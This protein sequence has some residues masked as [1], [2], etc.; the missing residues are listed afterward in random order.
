[1]TQAEACRTA[2]QPQFS[3]GE[4]FEQM[5]RTLTEIQQDLI[6]CWSHLESEF[7]SLDPY[8][9]DSA[10][11][12]VH[13]VALRRHDVRRLQHDLSR[14][15]ISSLGRSESY[16]MTNISKVLKLLHRIVQR[17][18]APPPECARELDLDEGRVILKNRTDLL[19]GTEPEHRKVRIMVTLP[20][21]A[22]EDC[23]LVRNL[24]ANGMDCA[25][26]NCAHD[27]QA[28]WRRMVENIKRAQT[29]TDRRCRICFDIAGP[30]LRTGAMQEGPKILK[31]KPFRDVFGRARNRR[32]F[33]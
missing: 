24:I 30:K 27:D 7:K 18:F 14:H 23:A 20:S 29:E 32:R 2:V 9:R 10:R 3:D 16:V 4:E 25:R 15:G 28:A 13:Y 6:N 19:L 8:A 33:C 26:I 12:L 21:E 31:C 1:M 22:A 5:I 11:N 17:P